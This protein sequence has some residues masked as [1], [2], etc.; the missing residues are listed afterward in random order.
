MFEKDEEG[1][2]WCGA[3]NLG[4]EEVPGAVSFHYGWKNNLSSNKLTIMIVE[5]ILEDKEPEFFM[6][7][8]I[9]EEQVK[10]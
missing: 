2:D 9:P 4:E 7:S 8:D 3:R 1:V 6:N 10:M 5:K